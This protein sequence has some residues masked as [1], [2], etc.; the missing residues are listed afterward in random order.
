MK[1]KKN[2]VNKYSAKKHLGI[3]VSVITVAELQHGVSSSIY[4]EKNAKNLADFLTGFTV[5]DFDS[6]AAVEYG[7]ICA[8]LYKKGK[9]IGPM[10]ML[11]GAH[12]KSIGLTLVTNNT[13]EF[14]RIDGLDIEDWLE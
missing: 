8:D 14:G 5:L 9:L 1:D 3:S 6:V 4:I 13:R 12:A 10:D 2:V 11:I 7:N